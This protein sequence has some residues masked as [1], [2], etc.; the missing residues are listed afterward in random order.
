LP[1]RLASGIDVEVKLLAIGGVDAAAGANLP[2]RQ[3]LQ[4][5]NESKPGGG[6]ICYRPNRYLRNSLSGEVDHNQPGFL[7]VSSRNPIGET[8]AH[9]IPE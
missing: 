3:P 8:F 5:F 7:A 9:T 1:V 6:W 4:I 2:V